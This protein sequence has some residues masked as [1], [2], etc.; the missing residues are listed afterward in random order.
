MQLFIVAA[1]WRFRG[2]PEAARIFEILPSGF[3]AIHDGIHLHPGELTAAMPTPNQVLANAISFNWFDYE[4]IPCF[5]SHRRRP[6]SMAGIDP[7]LRRDDGEL[8]L[9]SD[10]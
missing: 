6:V 4:S 2:A 7:G 3:V 5:L 10:L 9:G 1:C 8:S